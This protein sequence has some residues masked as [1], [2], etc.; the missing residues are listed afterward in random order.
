MI[1]LPLKVGLLVIPCLLVFSFV[2]VAGS[3]SETQDSF[4]RVL[5]SNIDVMERW[6]DLPTAEELY[7]NGPCLVIDLC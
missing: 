7:T 2:Q 1:K 3:A 4:G 5:L 6:P